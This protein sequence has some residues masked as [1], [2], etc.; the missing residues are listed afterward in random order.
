MITYIIENDMYY[1]FHQILLII[2][3]KNCSI[4]SRQFTWHIL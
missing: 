1:Y 2:Y 3:M 4:H